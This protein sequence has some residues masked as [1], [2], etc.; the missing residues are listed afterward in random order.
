MSSIYFRK[1]LIIYLR[2]RLA[3]PRILLLWLVLSA[4]ALWLSSAGTFPVIFST[5]ALLI[6]QFRLWDDLSDRK[7][8]ALRH[9]Q[10]VLVNTAHS[11][12][13]VWSCAGLTLPLAWMVND[14]ILIYIGL[15][16]AFALLYATVQARLLRTHLILL[17]YP[18]FI[19]LCARD[20]DPE[21][22]LRAGLIVYLLLCVYDLVNDAEL[23]AINGWPWLAAFELAAC[24]A[25]LIF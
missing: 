21:Q 25:L 17:K 22:W 1:D 13:F 7:H 23:R 12:G 18:I 11:K 9:P 24:A 10:R 4:C 20:A 5:M 3:V 6:A 14:R 2:S 15:L 19:W 8:D 16:A